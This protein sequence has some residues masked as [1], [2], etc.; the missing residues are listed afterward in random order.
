MVSG[1]YTDLLRTTIVKP[2]TSRHFSAS[3]IWIA[4]FLWIVTKPWRDYFW[5]VSAKELLH[6]TLSGAP[7]QSPDH[8]NTVEKTGSTL[9]KM[10]AGKTSSPDDLLVVYGS[11]SYGTILRR[12]SSFSTRLLRRRGLDCAAQLIHMRVSYYDG[13]LIS[14]R[15]TNLLVIA[16]PSLVHSEV[17]IGAFL[18]S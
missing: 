8:S 6:S 7:I 11:R 3:V 2:R 4:I 13:T 9:G 14:A 17:W 16:F 1:I 18:S 5:G 12:W 10:T 15:I